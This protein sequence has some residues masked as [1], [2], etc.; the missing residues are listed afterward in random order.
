MKNGH[1]DEDMT[2]E[3]SRSGVAQ[4]DG[5]VAQLDRCISEV[6]FRDRLVVQCGTFVLHRG[7]T[8]AAHHSRDPVRTVYHKYTR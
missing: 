8:T 4:V 3:H 5:A 7:S 6:K 2:R 1:D